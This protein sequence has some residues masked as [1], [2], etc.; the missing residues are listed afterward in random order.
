[1]RREKS[2]IGYFSTVYQTGNMQTSI[3]NLAFFFS[4]LQMLYLQTKIRFIINTKNN[5]ESRE[6][7]ENQF[8]THTTNTNK[9]MK[10][11][12]WFLILINIIYNHKAQLFFIYASCQMQMLISS[13]QS[14]HVHTICIYYPF[15][16]YF[17]SD[18]IK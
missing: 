12:I 8:F 13:I 11:R 14:T 18:E 15:Y 6:H 5:D 16:F 9:E 17:V 4:L 3:F 10:K 7:K 2:S 1:M